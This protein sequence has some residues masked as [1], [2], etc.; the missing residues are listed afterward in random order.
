MEDASRSE[1][2]IEKAEKEGQQ[3]ARVNIDTR[4]NN[5]VVDLR[6]EC[7]SHLSRMIFIFCY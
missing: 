1:V 2:D 7:P 4:L 6:V 3:F 5:R